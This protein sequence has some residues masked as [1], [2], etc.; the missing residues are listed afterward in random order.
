MRPAISGLIA[1]SFLRAGQA[2]DA[3]LQTLAKNVV[4]DIEKS[5]VRLEDPD[6][7]PYVVRIAQKLAGDCDSATPVAV[8][9]FVNGDPNVSSLP[10][11][12]LVV[13]T[14][15]LQRVRSE[16]ALA[17]A[18][19]QTLFQSILFHRDGQNVIW[20]GNPYLLYES[21]FPLRSISSFR[22]QILTADHRAA[23]CLSTAGYDPEEFLHDLR[24]QSVPGD[25]HA[26]RI[27]R[28]EA[29]IR[30]LGG[31][32][33]VLLST[34]NFLEMRSQLGAFLAKTHPPTLR[35]AGPR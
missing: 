15:Y 10:G 24:L 35:A 26:E 16:A 31:K 25:F 20:L 3:A 30:E 5:S 34:S 22:T 11:R 33:T 7:H 1:V 19:A 8:H 32:S 29:Q 6:I 28:L 18:L 14:G 9:I 12:T 4:N 13:H 2:D 23:A 21:R 27:W 17:G